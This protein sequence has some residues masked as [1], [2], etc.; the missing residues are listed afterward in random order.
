M[1]EN[2]SQDDTTP[3]GI[4]ALLAWLLL[5]L[6]KITLVAFLVLGTVLVLTQLAGALFAQQ[7]L[8]SGA[9]DVL[10]APTTAC[11]AITGLAGFAIAYVLKWDT[12]D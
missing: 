9:M 8:V 6:F 2:S 10:F 11:A 7:T 4:R 12:S 1:S 5:L 3:T